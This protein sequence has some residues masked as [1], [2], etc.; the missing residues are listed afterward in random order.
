MHNDHLAIR[1]KSTSELFY[2]NKHFLHRNIKHDTQKSTL[3]LW[4]YAVLVPD[5]LFLLNF[6]I[7]FQSN[8]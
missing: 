5:T 4:H 8:F 3:H 1:A 7:D 2:L 6:E